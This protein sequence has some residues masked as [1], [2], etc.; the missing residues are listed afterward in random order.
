MRESV[1]MCARFCVCNLLYLFRYIH[2]RENE[3]EQ[4]MN[5]IL[6]WPSF[7]ATLP[8]Y[9]HTNKQLTVLACTYTHTHAHVHCVVNILLS[10]ISA[11]CSCCATHLPAGAEIMKFL[12]TI[13]R[14]CAVKSC[15]ICT[16]YCVRH[17]CLPTA[18]PV[19]LQRRLHTYIQP[20]AALAFA[21][22]TIHPTNLI[23]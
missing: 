15:R 8:S 18:L 23:N 7:S 2:Q 9:V 1:R 14:N 20:L 19:A 10:Y 5:V 13:A 22:F 6:R 12:R 4:T 11:V 17:R 3:Y 16:R 21:F